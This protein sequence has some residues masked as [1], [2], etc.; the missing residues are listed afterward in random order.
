MNEAFGFM[1][2]FYEICYTLFSS[3]SYAAC[4]R[5][6]RICGMTISPET[7]TRVGYRNYKYTSVSAGSAYRASVLA[8]DNFNG[9]HVV[10]GRTE[11]KGELAEIRRALEGSRPSL[12]GQK[13]Q[14]HSLLTEYIH[15]IFLQSKG[16]ITPTEGGTMVPI[17]K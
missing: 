6:F 2:S 10:R 15:T 14:P 3:I 16:F 5:V 11:A 7:A 8:R 4:R 9:D 13:R 12:D 17:V 1:S